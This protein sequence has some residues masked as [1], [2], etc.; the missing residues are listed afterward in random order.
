MG[1]EGPG[2]CLRGMGGGGAKYFLGGP[3]CPPR[4]GHHKAGRSDFRNQRFEPKMQ[5]MQKVPFTSEQQGSEKIPK[6]ES[7]EN[8]ENA[9]DADTKT[10]KMRK[11]H[12]ALQGAPARGRQL[13]FTFQVLQTLYSKR[14][15]HPFL[16]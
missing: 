14:Q 6:S 16:P 8:A 12:R 13:Y 4:A 11:I 7:A 2:G 15:K 1:H 9:E 10:R 3:K 5:K